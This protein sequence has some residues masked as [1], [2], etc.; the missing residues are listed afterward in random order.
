VNIYDA[1][2]KRR[3][4]KDYQNLTGDFDFDFAK[5][6]GYKWNPRTQLLKIYAA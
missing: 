6:R 5:V 2:T 3:V 1:N 4:A